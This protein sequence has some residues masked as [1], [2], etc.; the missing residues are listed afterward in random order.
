MVTTGKIHRS[1][2]HHTQLAVDASRLSPTL[3]I[4]VPAPFFSISV[5]ERECFE[6]V[7]SIVLDVD[8]R[9]FLQWFLNQS[10]EEPGTQGSSAIIKSPQ[11]MSVCRQDHL[12]QD[13]HQD[14]KPIW[15]N[16]IN[17]IRNMGKQALIKESY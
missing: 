8:F 15:K 11:S 13:R 5:D 7:F 12:N 2:F 4:V 1:I 16:C 6:G 9:S 3:L 14:K 17:L 10:W